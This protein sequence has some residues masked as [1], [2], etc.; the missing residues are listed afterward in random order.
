MSSRR[1]AGSEGVPELEADAVAV[2]HGSTFL[3]SNEAGDVVPGT[4]AGLF[5]RDTRIVSE[6]GLTI[7][8]ERPRPLSSGQTGPHAARFFL[9][10]DHPAGGHISIQRQRVVW[11]DVREDIT[12]QSHRNEPTKLTLELR[13]SADFADLF[14]VKD[15][16]DVPV[17]SR[18]THDADRGLLRFEGLR[19]GLKLMLR[20][21]FERPVRIAEDSVVFE[22]D[23]PPRGAWRTQVAIDWGEHPPDGEVRWD[24]DP[25]GEARADLERWT[26]SFPTLRTGSDALRRVFER[27]IADLGALRLRVEVPGEELVLPAAGLPWFMTIFGRDSLLT[28]YEAM[29]F[30]PELAEGALR[31]LA[32]LQ[33]EGVDEFRDEEP[34]KILHEVRSGPLTLARIAPF[35]PYYG[36]VDA[37]PLWLVV[38]SEHHR[39][40]RDP[41][42]V[43]ALW[44]AALRALEWIDVQIGRDPR[45]YLTYRSHSP[46]GL[47]NQGWKDSW[48]GVAFHDGTLAEPPIALCEVKGYVHD[49]W[50]RVAQLADD[51]VGDTD[52]AAELRARASELFERFQRDFWV[53]S[54]GGF[55]ALALDHDGRQVDAMTSNMGHL[56]WS[57]MVP[58]DR[59]EIVVRQLFTPQMWTGWGV[60]TVSTAD[61]GYDPVGYHVGTVWP[62]DNA[63]ISAGLARAG[64]RTEANRLATA[65]IEAATHQRHRLPEVFAGYERDRS[66]FPVRYPTASSPQAWATVAPLLWLRL[67]LGLDSVDGR[68]VL[69][70]KIPGSFGWI[71]LLGLDLGGRRHDLVARGSHGRATPSKV[72]ASA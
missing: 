11:D 7:D 29:P 35:D 30:A 1:P 15:E 59:A 41:D 26:Q 10:A 14:E 8:G 47:T 52:L 25:E 72:P 63:I 45:G 38:L 5:H 32:A 71:E 64:F 60:R 53:P 28:C 48:D 36:S 51:V 56:L 6:F 17:R 31:A 66:R 19:D 24:E 67:M 46:V 33:G 23:L 61:R 3:I 20:V 34:G 54:R 22:V 70:P 68:L 44:P 69:D 37:T 2:L 42:V 27:S 4:V 13:F 9:V 49:A 65:M 50:L 55:Y 21:A 43:R 39:F 58:A 18:S 57:A 12:V 40:A 16:Q 62:H